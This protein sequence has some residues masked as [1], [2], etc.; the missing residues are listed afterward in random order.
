MDW[1]LCVICQA[2]SNEAL[3]CPLK[4]PGSEDKAGPFKAFLSR[5]CTFRELGILPMP[6]THLTENI[7]VDDMIKNEAKWHKSCYNK[8]GQDRIDRVRKR[9]RAE[10]E[11][12]SDVSSARRV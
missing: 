9:R 5:V 1:A 4:G 3:K 8:F 11:E 10:M 12:E 6:L 2:P 7:T